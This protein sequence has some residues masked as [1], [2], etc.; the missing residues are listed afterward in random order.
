MNYYVVCILS[1]LGLDNLGF[2]VWFGLP[3]GLCLHFGLCDAVAIF[4]GIWLWDFLVACFDCWV[5]LGLFDCV[6]IV[7]IY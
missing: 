3:D 5:V 6:I 1:F 2:G 4:L 7:G